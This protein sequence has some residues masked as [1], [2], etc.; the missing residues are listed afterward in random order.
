[1]EFLQVL[2]RLDQPD[3]HEDEHQAL[4]PLHGPGHELAVD[5]KAENSHA[6][7]EV[8]NR[9]AGHISPVSCPA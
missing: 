9:L 4:V 5:E 7:N 2:G 6:N 1:M 3:E 8:E